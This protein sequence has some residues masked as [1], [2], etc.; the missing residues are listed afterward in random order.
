MA[1]A[2]AI[3]GSRGTVEHITYREGTRLP[4]GTMVTSGPKFGVNVRRN[5]TNEETREQY[6]RLMGNLSDQWRQGVNPRLVTERQRRLTD[7]Y[8]RTMQGLDATGRGWAA[9]TR[10]AVLINRKNNRRK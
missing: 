5:R 4:N 8:T 1:E 10:P 6:M 3:K 7:A 9:W 2:K